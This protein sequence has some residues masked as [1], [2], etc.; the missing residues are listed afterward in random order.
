MG[1]QY[2]VRL[3]EPDILKE[4]SM[5]NLTKFLV[6]IAIGVVITIGLAGCASTTNAGRYDNT[7]P[8]ENDCTLVVGKEGD[9]M[10]TKFDNQTVSWQ[11]S[12]TNMLFGANYFIIAVPVGEHTLSG[13]PTTS[14]QG[15]LVWR[16]RPRQNSSLKREKH[17]LSRWFPE[18]SRLARERYKVSLLFRQT[19][20]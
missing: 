14:V 7:S 15:L 16:M 2:N 18:T 12:P 9:T 11:G 13:G 20:R 3:Y 17:I 1:W 10:I 5:K 8:V 6:I 4:G 19:H